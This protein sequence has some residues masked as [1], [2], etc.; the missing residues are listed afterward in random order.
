MTTG[1]GNLLLKNDILL[2]SGTNEVEILVF[3]IGGYRLGI[4]V[5]KVREILPSQRITRLPESHPSVVGCFRLRDIVIP[6]VSLEKHLGLEACPETPNN[7]I[8]TEFNKSQIAFL[9]DE[10]ER[11]HRIDWEQIAPAP[12]VVIDC[13]S[14]VT[15]VTNLEGHLV[16]MLDF[17]LIT[18]EIGKNDFSSVAVENPNDL[19]RESVRVMVVDDSPTVRCALESTLQDSDYGQVF[20]FENGRQAWEWLQKRLSETSTVSEIADLV[21]SDVEMPSMDGLHLTKNIKSHPQLS[22]LPVALYSSILTPDNYKKGESV[23][24][25]AQITKPEL[26]R[27]VELADEFTM[28]RSAR[29]KESV[30]K[31]ATESNPLPSPSVD[32]TDGSVGSLTDTA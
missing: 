22:C 21:I 29:S 23:G 27:I 16:L 11:I 24:A 30:E 20:A 26:A 19:P 8:L 14:T 1:L 17:E 6:C 10:V 15:A 32:L 28:G 31:P 3:R 18:A 4:N 9:V 12:Q 2:E 25:D 7:L 13:H 5:A